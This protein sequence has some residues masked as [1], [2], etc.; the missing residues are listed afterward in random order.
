VKLQLLRP[1]RLTRLSQKKIPVLFVV[2][3]LQEMGIKK[4]KREIGYCVRKILSV[5][6]AALNVVISILRK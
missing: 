6:F 5:V 3:N 4:L 2:T 1:Q